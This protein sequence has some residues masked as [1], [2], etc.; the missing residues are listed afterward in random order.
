MILRIIWKSE[1]YESLPSPGHTEDVSRE[2]GGWWF[3]ET[4]S[5][6]GERSCYKV[7]SRKSF[8]GG[9]SMIEVLSPLPDTFIATPCWQDGPPQPWVR[10]QDGWQLPSG[11]HVIQFQG[12]Q[13]PSGLQVP[14]YM[15]NEAQSIL[16]SILTDESRVSKGLSD[17][18]KPA[19]Q[20]STQKEVSPLQK[21]P[22]HES[23]DGT[24]HSYPSVPKGP[25][26]GQVQLPE[27]R[28]LASASPKGVQTGSLCPPRLLPDGQPPRTKGHHP[29]GRH[30][31]P[32]RA[33]QVSQVCLID[34][35][36][37]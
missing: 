5:S 27:S 31:P 15:R 24:H 23:S 9:A 8:D 3:S 37:S 35:Q 2:E 33:H 1:S 36:L 12:T 30:G 6:S 18:S 34:P 25:Y 22:L 4:F 29:R 10:L 26:Q 28:C 21:K 11:L 7:I 13:L 20:G 19:L 17:L 32:S 16:H 14:E